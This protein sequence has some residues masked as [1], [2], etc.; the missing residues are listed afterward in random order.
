MEAPVRYLVLACD[1]DGT[2]AT[3]GRVDEASIDAL[4]RLLASGRRLILVTGREL[5]DV[6]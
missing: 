5:A 2:L 3:S 6:H 4:E 1:Y